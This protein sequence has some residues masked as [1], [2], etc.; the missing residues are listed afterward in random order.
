M[1]SPVFTGF[2]S[3]SASSSITY[4]TVNSS[5]VL[6]HQHLWRTIS[7]ETQVIKFWPNG[8]TMFQPDYHRQACLPKFPVSAADLWT[9]SLHTSPQHGRSRFSSSTLRLVFILLKHSEKS[10]VWY[11]NSRPLLAFRCECWHGVFLRSKC[12]NWLRVVWPSYACT[13][14]NKHART[15]CNDGWRTCL[16]HGKVGIQ[17]KTLQV[18]ERIGNFH[19]SYQRRTRVDRQRRQQSLLIL[20]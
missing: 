10:Q 5:V 15:K 12:N 16:L 6:L 4:R 1:R 2:M 8:S 3:Q 7:I 13:R 17:W 18:L 9:P 20:Q 19:E 14:M 11:C